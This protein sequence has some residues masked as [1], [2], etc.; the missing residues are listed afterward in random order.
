MGL[1]E[2]SEDGA[3]LACIGQ[4]DDH[5]VTEVTGW[6]EIKGKQDVPL[7]HYIVSWRS[8]KVGGSEPSQIAIKEYAKGALR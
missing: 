5:I 6:L 1:I 3:H 2:Q 7:L 4:Y 8:V